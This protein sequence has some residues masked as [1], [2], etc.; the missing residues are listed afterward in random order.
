MSHPPLLLPQADPAPGARDPEEFI[1]VTR[2]SVAEFRSLLV[3]GDL[4]L[5]SVSVALRCR[6]T[7]KRSL[8]LGFVL[9][10]VT[11][12]LALQHLESNGLL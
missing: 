1:Q 2:V 11:G 3:S 9:Q 6:V 12:M 10:V 7:P 8:R 4:M 5:P